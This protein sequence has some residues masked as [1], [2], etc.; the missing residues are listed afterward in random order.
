MAPL[1]TVLLGRNTLNTVFMLIS[2][3]LLALCTRLLSIALAAACQR[4]YGLCGPVLP[5]IWRSGQRLPRMHL[6]S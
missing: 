6:A 1:D 4:N 3:Y 5:Y 2:P